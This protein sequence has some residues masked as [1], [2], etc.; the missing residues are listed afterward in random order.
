MTTDIFENSSWGKPG[1]F[2]TAEEFIASGEQAG[3]FPTAVRTCGTFVQD[4]DGTMLPVAGAQG[5]VCEY[6]DSSRKPMGVNGSRYKATTPE[7]WREVIKAAVAAGAKPIHHHSWG[8][9]V[10]A[11]FEVGRSGGIMSTLVLGD[12]FDGSTRFVGGTSSTRLGCANAMARQMRV[13]RKSGNDWAAF[14]HT[15]SLEE[16]INRMIAGVERAISAGE[17]VAEM[18]Q[19]ASSLHLPATMAK[20]AFD[21][22]FPL[23]AEDA[24]KRAK[25]VALRAREDA[26]KAAALPI[27]RVGDAGNVATLWNAATYLV[28]RKPDGQIRKTRGNSSRVDALMFGKRGQRLDEVQTLVDVIMADGR[29]KA[30]TVA[31]ATAAG[32]P[33]DNMG[34]DLLQAILDDM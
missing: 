15:S 4:T 30:M 17:T 12:S 24:S 1:T 5:I 32:V 33:E 22:L 13:E 11:Q 25:T 26:R 29:V 9:K 28:D 16:K 6:A 8:D 10:M 2:T 14:S 34:A 31:Q 7:Q 21:I 20:A 18:F 27:N 19:K 23:P 3:D